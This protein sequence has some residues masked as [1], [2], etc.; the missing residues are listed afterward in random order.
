MEIRTSR[1]CSTAGSIFANITGTE[2]TAMEGTQILGTR[3][4]SLKN[5]QKMGHIKLKVKF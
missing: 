4:L 1:K 3:N 2:L 5:I